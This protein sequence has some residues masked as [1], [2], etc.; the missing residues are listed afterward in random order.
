M[1]LLYYSEFCYIIICHIKLEPIESLI[2]VL[3]PGNDPYAFVEFTDH[4]GAAAA[5]AAMNKRLFL[6]KVGGYRSVHIYTSEV[7]PRNYT[8][9]LCH[10]CNGINAQ[11]ERLVL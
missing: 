6:D 7:L 5:L 11:L 9:T 2:S 8:C 4:Q 3:Q 1:A 10:T